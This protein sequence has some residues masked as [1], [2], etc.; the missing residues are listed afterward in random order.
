MA[1]VERRHCALQA[2][3]SALCRSSG[4]TSR[5]LQPLLHHSSDLPDVSLFSL[6]VSTVTPLRGS[7]TA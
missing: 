2:E 5:A 3:R 1:G 7:P 6:P 4:R